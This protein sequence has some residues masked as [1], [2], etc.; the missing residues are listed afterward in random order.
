MLSLLLGSL[1]GLLP[2]LLSGLLRFHGIHER[3]LL[4]IDAH[5]ATLASSVG[6]VLV[7]LAYEDMLLP[8]ACC[9]FHAVTD[10]AIRDDGDVVNQEGETT[11]KGVTHQ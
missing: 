11:R 3:A 8:D 1:P 7:D 10:I 6:R 5:L 4:I 9:A 2:L